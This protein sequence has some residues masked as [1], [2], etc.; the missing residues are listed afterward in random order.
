MFRKL[1]LELVAQGFRVVAPDMLGFGASDKPQGYEIYDPRRQAQRLQELMEALDIDSWYHLCHDVGGVWTWELLREVPLKIEKLVLLNTIIYEEGF[2]PPMR[3]SRNVW[4]RFYVS[5][6]HWRL[7]A[8]MMID[9]TLK[10]GLN[11]QKLSKAEKEGYW[12]PMCEGGHRGIFHF[13][14]QT[15]HKLEDYRPVLQNLGVPAMVIWGAK[16]P[17]LQWQPQADRVMADLNIPKEQVHILAEASHF[18]PE[19]QSEEIAELMGAFLRPR[20]GS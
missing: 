14:T 19:E 16:D 20:L 2:R 8:R 15:C 17:M 12:Q 11:G 3:F 18:I 10:N 4:S 7:T 5:L 6:Y 1:I 13:F 9:A